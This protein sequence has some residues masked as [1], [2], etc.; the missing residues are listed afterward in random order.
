MTLV[1]DASMIF[2]WFLAD[3][4]SAK[5]DGVLALV[6]DEGAVLP[7]IWAVEVVNALTMS[8]RRS[9]FDAV[10]RAQY[11]GI[12]R[13]L[14]IETDT[15]T[16]RQAWSNTVMLADRHRLTLYDA[17]YLELALRRR[18]PLASLDAALLRAATAEAVP[19]F[20]S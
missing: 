15:E 8:M 14:P 3:E 20:P 16:N 7:V 4:A 5:S 10:Q 1:L 11:L 13:E 19:T 12:L 2:P 9:R 18:L 6:R 17:T